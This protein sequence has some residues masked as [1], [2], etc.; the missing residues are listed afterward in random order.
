MRTSEAE[1]IHPGEIVE[2]I[3]HTQGSFGEFVEKSQRKG[4]KSTV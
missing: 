1:T 2:I 3:C 4:R